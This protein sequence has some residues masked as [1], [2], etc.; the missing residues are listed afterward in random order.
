MTHASKDHRA[1][2]WRALFDVEPAL[3]LPV[4]HVQ[5]CHTIRHS[6]CWP[7]VEEESH[8]Y[9]PVP[10]QA[11]GMT[12]TSPTSECCGQWTHVRA[13]SNNRKLP[14]VSP[15]EVVARELARLTV[16][17]Q[18]EVG[19]RV[20]R[21]AGSGS[22]GSASP[23]L[24]Q[25][26]TLLTRDT[27]CLTNLLQPNMSMCQPPSINEAACHNMSERGTSASTVCARVPIARNAALAGCRSAAPGPSHA[28]APLPPAQTKLRLRQR[29]DTR[30]KPLD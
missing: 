6:Q 18:R 4:K 28:R 2:G 26:E 27:R 12:V 20:V 1:V 11:V 9:V 17:E 3:T 13:A 22:F 25:R 16:L 21:V 24:A 8:W 5:A 10:P 23:V 7:V 29:A 30:D 14:S 19:L 15:A